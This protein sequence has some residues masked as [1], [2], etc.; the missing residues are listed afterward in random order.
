MGVWQ[1]LRKSPK[2]VAIDPVTPREAAIDLSAVQGAVLEVEG[3]P[4]LVSEPL[5]AWITSNIAS[6]ERSAAWTEAAAQW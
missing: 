1:W 4:R 3:L 6:E 5:E 2:Q